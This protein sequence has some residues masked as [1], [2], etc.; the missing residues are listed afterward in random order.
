MN[1]CGAIDLQIKQEWIQSKDI[2]PLYNYQVISSDVDVGVAP[3]KPQKWS[4]QTIFTETPIYTKPPNSF[5]CSHLKA[6]REF[7]SRV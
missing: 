6:L 7:L 4:T 5:V 1:E 2:H 3:A